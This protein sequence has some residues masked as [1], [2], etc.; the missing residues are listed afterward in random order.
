M[1]PS[2]PL[3][4]KHDTHFCLHWFFFDLTATCFKVMT[5]LCG[6]TVALVGDMTFDR[7]P[8]RWASAWVPRDVV[9]GQLGESSI[10]SITWVYF[11]HAF[12]I[13]E[14]ER[15]FSAHLLPQRTPSLHTHPQLP[16]ANT[17]EQGFAWIRRHVQAVRLRRQRP[18]PQGYP[19]KRIWSVSTYYLFSNYISF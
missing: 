3:E 19:G 13:S 1:R 14:E 2:P 16:R 11:F 17:V 12:F 5:A 8:A 4:K 9:W 7:F 10:T 15:L 6:L 18:M